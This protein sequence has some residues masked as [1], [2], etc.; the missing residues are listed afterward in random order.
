MESSSYQYCE[1]IG[2]LSFSLQIGKLED[3]KLRSNQQCF[4]E[5]ILEF[6]SLTREL[7]FIKNRFSNVDINT[8]ILNYVKEQRTLTKNW[9]NIKSA[10]KKL[11]RQP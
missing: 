11:I 1:D 2:S 3:Y 7:E 9:A 8:S 6:D 10:L 4:D 5:I